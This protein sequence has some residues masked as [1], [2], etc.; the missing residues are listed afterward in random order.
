MA[1]IHLMTEQEQKQTL[2]SIR[3]CTYFQNMSDEELLR[4]LSF[5]DIKTYEKNSIIRI[6]RTW[7]RSNNRL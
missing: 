5:S 4:L 7:K 1:K 3:E 6:W 2:F